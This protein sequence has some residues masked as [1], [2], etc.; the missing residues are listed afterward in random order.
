MANVLVG[1]RAVSARQ[2]EVGSAAAFEVSTGQLVQIIDLAG[3]QV[4]SFVAVGKHGAVQRLS[5]STTITANASLVLKV[6][7]KLYSQHRKPMFEI[8]EDSVARHDLLTSPL[9]VDD[10]TDSKTAIK[11]STA[12]S[13]AA[14]AVDAGIDSGDVSDPINFFKHVVVKQRGELDVK[15]SFA[16]RNDTVVLRVLADC[17]VVVA[18]AY[19]EKKAGIANAVAPRGRVPQILVRVY[20]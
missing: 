5:P 7:D 13:L 12:T 1:R 8:V 15:D 2:L 16:E 11:K 4:A 14:A 17:T 10:D 18:N 19:P 9:P 6:G 3:K 20:Q